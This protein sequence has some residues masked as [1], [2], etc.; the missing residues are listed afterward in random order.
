M[1]NSKGAL[2]TPR[3]WS[4]ER[5]RALNLATMNCTVFGIQTTVGRQSGYLPVGCKCIAEAEQENSRGTSGPAK[6]GEENTFHD[7]ACSIL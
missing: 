5:E 4:F 2:T 6:E 7:S 1:D 3:S